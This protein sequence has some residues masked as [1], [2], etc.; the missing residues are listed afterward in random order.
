M[1]YNNLPE[2]ERSLARS[3]FTYWGFQDHSFAEQ[4]RDWLDYSWQRQVAS[5]HPLRICLYSNDVQIERRRKGRVKNCDIRFFPKEF[6][7]DTTFWVAG[8][9]LCMVFSRE[10]PHYGLQ[11]KDA[12]LTA[13]L[14][15]VFRVLWGLVK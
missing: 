13:N 15:M 12:R 11:I 1:L 5:K 14:R 8:D 9:Y 3:D 2:W 7:F 4:Y 6:S 10:K